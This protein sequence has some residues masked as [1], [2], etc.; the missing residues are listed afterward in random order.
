MAIRGRRY[1]A[2]SYVRPVVLG[3]RYPPPYRRY[4][5]PTLTTQIPRRY[6]APTRATP[7]A[8]LPPIAAPRPFVRL[9]QPC[10]AI[11]RTLVQ[12]PLAS[13]QASSRVVTSQQAKRVNVPQNKIR[14]TAI[15]HP[16]RPAV[17]ARAAI[18]VVNRPQIVTPQSNRHS[19]PV[20]VVNPPAPVVVRQRFDQ[21]RV[22]HLR[23]QFPYPNRRQP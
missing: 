10:P 23:P 5:R 1:P 9:Q 7:A 21:Q 19:F 8:P 22:H 16:V 15:T 3:R 13:R 4:V 17:P 11:L 20:R 2:A 6:Q 18:P 14:S 12:K